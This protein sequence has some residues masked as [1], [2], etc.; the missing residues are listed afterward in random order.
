MEVTHLQ[1]NDNH[2]VIGGGKAK[3]FSISTS[4]EFIEVLS[5]SLYA[6]KPLAMMRE[7]MCNQWDAHI[8]AGRKDKPI[9]ITIEDDK[10]SFRD[11]GNGIADDMMED[12]YCTY[13]E[14]TKRSE[15]ATTGGFGLGSKSPFAIS[16][17]FTVTSMHNGIKTIYAVSKG[18]EATDHLPSLT[19]VVTLPTTESG[20]LV[21]IPIKLYCEEN[22][23]AVSDFL[24]L[25]VKV[26][27]YGQMKAI[28]KSG[29]FIKMV[30]GD[31]IGLAS[32]DMGF[33][34]VP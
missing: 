14:S 30:H 3:G 21:E 31:E 13:G 25:A 2:V 8:T 9:E 18:S 23:G 29:S 27:K 16:D 22:R 7:V 15:T 11:Y 4:P 5:S 32:T 28:I 24:D 34:I 33:V 17:T 19:P 12:V 10:I 1:E 26:A 20:L 6:D